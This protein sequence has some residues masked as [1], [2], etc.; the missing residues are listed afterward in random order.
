MP[1][2]MKL[3]CS[4]SRRIH[5]QLFHR[6]DEHRTVT[7]RL[8]WSCHA[9]GCTGFAQVELDATLSELVD[10]A[11]V[12]RS[13]LLRQTGVKTPVRATSCTSASGDGCAQARRFQCQL[14]GGYINP[15]PP[16]MIG[17]EF[18]L[19][20]FRAEIINYFCIRYL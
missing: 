17:T 1:S 16:I 2:S 18:L 20:E 7:A 14:G 3:T 8:P 6:V 9:A 13:C 15:I 4:V 12:E 19:A 11:L 5:R 10:V